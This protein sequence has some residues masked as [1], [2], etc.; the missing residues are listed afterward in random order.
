M[1]FCCN[2][3]TL[4]GFNVWW[5]PCSLL[6]PDSMFGGYRALYSCRIQCLVG[7]CVYRSERELAVISW[8]AQVVVRSLMRSADDAV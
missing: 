6:L 8:R 4:A 5:V 3:I 1:L 2:E 7:L